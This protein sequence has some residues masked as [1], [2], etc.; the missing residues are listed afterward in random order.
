MYEEKE[1]KYEKELSKGSKDPDI[2]KRKLKQYKEAK[3]L[4]ESEGESVLYYYCFSYYYN[5]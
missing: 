5:I 1:K 2:A 3:S 4:A